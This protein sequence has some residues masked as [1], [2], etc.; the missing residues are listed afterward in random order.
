[1]RPFSAWETPESPHVNM[2]AD[3]HGGSAPA[4]TIE[5]LSFGYGGQPVLDRLSVGIDPGLTLVRGGDG[6][7]KTTLLRLM[8][9]TLEPGSGR[10]RIRLEEGGGKSD[11]TDEAS[12]PRCS[13][14][15]ATAAPQGDDDAV[16]GECLRGLRRR[17]PRLDDTTLD[18]LVDGFALAP[19]LGKRLFMLST[20][21]RRKL[22]IAA[23]LASGAPL[24]LIDDPFG[25]LDRPSIAAVR[26]VLE[27]AAG[28]RHRMVVVAHHD[29][30]PGIRPASLIDLGD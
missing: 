20:G 21:T 9:G 26:Q 5:A 14:F 7:G 11:V 23:A 13:I 30:L 2:S 15:F 27:D 17:W 18:A 25:A 29:H 16:A 3:P 24:T 4:L 1:M 28:W 10:V 22:W 8:A 19:H 6:R 12:I